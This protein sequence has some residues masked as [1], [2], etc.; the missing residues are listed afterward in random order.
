LNISNSA[1]SNSNRPSIKG[2]L[3][4]ALTVKDM[5]T[6]KTI[7]TLNQDASNVPVIIQQSSANAKKDGLMF[8]VFS[9]AEIIPLIIRD[10]CSK[11]T[12]NNHI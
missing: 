1:K 8:D 10:V 9:V 7:A 11:R 4:N 3:H 6:Q 5:D 2:T 12:F